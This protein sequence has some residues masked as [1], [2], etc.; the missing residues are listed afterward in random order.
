M[1]QKK[2]EIQGSVALFARKNSLYTRNE[3]NN[4]EGK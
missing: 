2:I 3:T 4:R 1:E